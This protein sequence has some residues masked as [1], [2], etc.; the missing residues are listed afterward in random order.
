MTLFLG[1]GLL[2]EFTH[3]NLPMISNSGVPTAPATP[4]QFGNPRWKENTDSLLGYS[5]N[6][7]G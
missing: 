3:L 2:M 4:Q 6:A 7:N 5:F 1:A